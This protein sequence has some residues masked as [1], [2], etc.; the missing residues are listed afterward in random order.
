MIFQC[1]L[2]LMK[3]I[4]MQYFLNGQYQTP[5]SERSPT[6]SLLLSTPTPHII[7]LPSPPLL[8]C[9]QP[10]ELINKC[11]NQQH[12]YS[13]DKSDGILNCLPL[14]KSLCLFHMW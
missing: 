12:G 7:F 1:L 2:N 10:S 4:N 11:L 6:P 13:S 5:P 8:H 3:S 9:A 14:L